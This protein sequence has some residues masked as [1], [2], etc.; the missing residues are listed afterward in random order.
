[1]KIKMIAVKR[2]TSVPCIPL[3]PQF[4][5]GV[6][7]TYQFVDD[8]LCEVSCYDDNG[9]RVLLPEHIGDKQYQALMSAFDALGDIVKAFE[10]DCEP[11]S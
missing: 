5:I 9:D 2:H 8:A 7:K 1:M 6:M 11:E 10:A 4:V 3:T